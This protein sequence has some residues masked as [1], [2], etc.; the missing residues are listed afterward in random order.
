MEHIDWHIGDAGHIA[1]TGTASADKTAN[2]S[3]LVAGPAS[4]GD[5]T[6][7]CVFRR[8]PRFDTQGLMTTPYGFVLRF[9]D[10]ENYY[11]VTLLPA[12]AI[13]LVRMY[14]GEREIL[15]QVRGYAP[16]Y[17][18]NYADLTVR[19]ATITVRLNGRVV[20]QT[21]DRSHVAGRVGFFCDGPQAI[22]YRD[23]QL[24]QTGSV[25]FAYVPL[26][27]VKAPYVIW[28]SE[29]KGVLMWETNR[30]AAATVTYQP[31]NGGRKASVAVPPQGCVQRVVLSHLAPATRY[32]YRVHMEE[33]NPGGGEFRTDPGP[34]GAF[35]AGFIGDTHA[36][37][38]RFKEFNRLLAQH[39]PDFLINLG[40]VVDAAGH[41]DAWDA[42]FFRPGRRLFGRAPVYVA[43]GEQDQVPD[44]HWYNT[45]LPYPGSGMEVKDEAKSAYYA[46]TYG[47]TAIVMVDNYFDFTPGS[48]QYE[49]LKSKL[50]SKRFQQATWRIVCGHEPPFSVGRGRW[51]PGNPDV[52]EH[53]LPLCAEYGVQL[54]VG[55]KEHTY[56][57]G[58]VDDVI[59]L[60]NGGGSGYSAPRAYQFGARLLGYSTLQYSIMRIKGDRLEWTCYSIRDEVIDR[61]VLENGETWPAGTAETGLTGDQP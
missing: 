21:Q 47:N 41:V 52:R 5:Y 7:R 31:V 11:A 53:L 9:R 36:S 50:A 29:D 26:L 37:P 6:L 1:A 55:G 38:E 20:L 10:P 3:F 59:V 42:F 32:E 17:L 44:R 39:H 18:D 51:Q 56:K 58:R 22:T 16:M 28:A 25:P 24:F 8:E 2:R 13:A 54:L 45:F 23:I 49:W 61:F 4:E 60:V 33:R 30:P 46:L 48:R 27:M 40:G 14:G 34:E 12:G 43:I 35:T 15:E 19:K 57:R